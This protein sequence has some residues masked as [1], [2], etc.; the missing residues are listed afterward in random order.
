MEDDV[1][2]ENCSS[3]RKLDFLPHLEILDR[4]IAKTIPESYLL[5]S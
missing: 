5:I 2:I 3:D 1:E 4:Y